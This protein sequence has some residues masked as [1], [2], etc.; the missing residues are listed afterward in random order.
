MSALSHRVQEA[1]EGI[2][3]P[4]SV[5]V[6]MPLDIVSMGLIARL[7]VDDEGRV[8]VTLLP[9][10]PSCTLIASIMEAVEKRLSEIAGVS[11]LEV[12]LTN[13]TLWTEALM[14]DGARDA[15]A[16]RRVRARSSLA[17]EIAAT[18]NH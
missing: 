8:A 2:F 5:A 4:C 18:D 14:S 1:L 9:T 11:S 7:A 12:T 10:S 17:E 15:L 6:G 13:E 3:D 16:N